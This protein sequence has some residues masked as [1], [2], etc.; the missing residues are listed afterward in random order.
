MATYG[1]VDEYQP[2]EDWD[3]YIERLEQYFAANDITDAT[4]MKN[5]LLCACGPA[6]YAMMKRLCAPEK[7]SAK[8]FAELKK[9]VK[10][11]VNPKP[12]VIAERYKFY[13][14]SQE[15]DESVKEFLAQLRGL[16]EHCNFG[17]FL[18]EAI[19][20]RF[21]CGLRSHRIQ[22]RL[23]TEAD[24]TLANATKI[25]AGIE[26]ADQEADRLKTDSVKVEVKTEVCKTGKKA[27]NFTSQ[28]TRE[29]SCHRCGKKGHTDDQC[30]YKK[31]KCHR[32]K[33]QGHLS[34]RC[35][36]N[37]SDSKKKTTVDLV[38]EKEKWPVLTL[39]SQL[40][41]PIWVTVKV[42]DVNFRFE[43][44]TGSPV[45]LI[46]ETAYKKYFTTSA[47]QDPDIELTSY[48][49]EDIPILGKFDARVNFQS[50]SAVLPLYVV[51]GNGSALL[52]RNWLKELGFSFNEVNRCSQTLTLKDLLDKYSVFDG[53]LGKIRGITAS[54]KMRA[55]AVPK[56]FKPRPV[57]YALRDK[58]SDELKRL[59]SLGVVE[60]VETSDWA[61][62]IVPVLKPDGSVRIC[63]DFKVTINPVL[64][65]PEYPLPRAEDLFTKLNGGAKF[66]KCDLSEAYQQVEL[67][68]ESQKYV[69][70]N[71]HL[72]L[73][74]YK[75]LPYGVASSPA[76]FQQTMEKILQGFE[77]VGC[78]LDDLIVTESNDEKHLRLLDK[79]LQRLENFGV[80]LKRSKCFFMQHSVEYFS[81]MVNAEGIHPSS[82]KLE[83]ILK[84]PEPRNVKELQS[85]LGIVNHYRKFI[86]DMSTLLDPLTQL[87]KKKITWFWSQNCKKAFKRLKKLLAS[88]KVLIHYDPEKL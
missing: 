45:S 12:L 42:E 28:P 36:R 82:K 20:D 74:R 15:Q 78:I 37:V 61:S 26:I 57:A 10:D 71:T 43:M 6:T 80:K 65:I 83:A 31:A 14:R 75:R 5:I 13:Q 1:K 9:L 39:K 48:T 84:L 88:S 72:G 18:D 33:R 68:K 60:K 40:T 4:K 30:F 58:I 64:E 19:R 11:H 53:T 51:E 81:F 35:P 62:P 23:L 32:C 52:G 29:K 8:T 46:P 73:Y 41:K 2:G 56:F 55:D 27:R 44:D 24:L 59:E 7:P 49:K 25:A 47:L 50:K 77:K 79:L 87:L 67:D 22:R 54:L 3:A 69:T 66:T 34:R 85:F 16:S 76:I 17:D 70:I 21:V 86:P 38:E 63:G